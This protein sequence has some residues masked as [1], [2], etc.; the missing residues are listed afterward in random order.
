MDQTR[1]RVTGS[2][3]GSGQIVESDSRSG[4]RPAWIATSEGPNEVDHIHGGKR[5]K[6]SEDTWRSTLTYP[7]IRI[8]NII[9]FG[10]FGW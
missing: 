10:T 9:G 3:R 5:K 4:N 1:D 7:E 8:G 2:D 6:R